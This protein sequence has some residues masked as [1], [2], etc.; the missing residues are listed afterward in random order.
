LEEV[1]IEASDRAL[2]EM[3]RRRRAELRARGIDISVPEGHPDTRGT[4]DSRV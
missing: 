3:G 2:D 1:D 4:D